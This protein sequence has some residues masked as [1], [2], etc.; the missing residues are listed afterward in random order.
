ME[1]TCP[2]DSDGSN[3]HAF[4]ISGKADDTILRGNNVINF[5]THVKLNGARDV[6]TVPYQFPNRSMYINNTFRYTKR[7]GGAV[8]HNALNID[9]GNGHVARGNAFVDM[10]H[11]DPDSRSASSI[12][13]K[14]SIRDLTVEQNLVVCQKH[15]TEPGDRR[16]IYSGDAKPPSPFCPTADC[17]SEKG[18]YRN[19]IVM[20]CQG[21]GNSN[22]ILIMNERDT[23]YEHNTVDNVKNNFSNDLAGANVLVRNNVLYKKFFFASP[24]PIVLS[25]NVTQ[26]EVG[27]LALWVAPKQAD[28]ALKDGSVLGAKVP[29]S[30]KTLYDFCGNQRGAMTHVGAIDYDSANAKACTDRIKQ[31]YSE[32]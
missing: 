13:F 24:S 30:D 32:L 22:G 26:D 21:V 28:F 6:D 29:R 9:G 8:P 5:K 31:W 17:T 10:A 3:E 27:S 4:H 2:E 25:G 16:G 1:G 20:A 14:M 18:I 12:Y 15:I 11:S 23:V 19:N 7:L